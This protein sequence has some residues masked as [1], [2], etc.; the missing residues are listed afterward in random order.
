MCVFWWD[1]HCLAGLG[2]GVVHHGDD[3]AGRWGLL[4]DLSGDRSGV[5][6]V[7]CTSSACWWR[8]VRRPCCVALRVR[9][10][11]PATAAHEVGQQV[12]LVVRVG[13]PLTVALDLHEMK[14]CAGQAASSCG[15]ERR[16]RRA[17][18]IDVSDGGTCRSTRS[19]IHTG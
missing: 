8:L 11:A 12:A 10:M 2:R 19:H 3:T 7:H 14:C 18:L 4:R 15:C 1:E 6:D 17:F 5:W 16:A 9:R 13:A